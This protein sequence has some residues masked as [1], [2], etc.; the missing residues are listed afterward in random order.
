ML[1]GVYV[2]LCGLTQPIAG[3]WQGVS[4]RASMRLD[5]SVDGLVLGGVLSWVCL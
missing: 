2:S 3:T 4:I 5:I 1:T